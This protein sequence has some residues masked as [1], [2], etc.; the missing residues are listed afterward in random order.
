MLGDGYMGEYNR[1]KTHLTGHL[2]IIHVIICKLCISIF[3]SE[4]RTKEKI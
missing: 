1:K 3:L 2:Q 4:K